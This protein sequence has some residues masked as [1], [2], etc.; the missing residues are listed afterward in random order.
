MSI[1]PE[2]IRDIREEAA[3]RVEATANEMDALEDQW[4]SKRR[5]WYAACL[6]AFNAGCTYEQLQSLSNRS[7]IRIA[8]V[9]KKERVRRGEDPED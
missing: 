2:D 6:D 3:A 4:T 1:T 5:E 7:R 8:Q 9:L